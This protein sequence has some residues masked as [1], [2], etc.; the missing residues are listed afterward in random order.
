M[1]PETNW[2]FLKQEE[3]LNRVWKFLLIRAND[4]SK[5]EIPSFQR[6][7]GHPAHKFWILEMA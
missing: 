3:L 6:Q 2:D 4:K 7:A 5:M 1:I